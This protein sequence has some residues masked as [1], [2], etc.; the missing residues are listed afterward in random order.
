MQQGGM[1]ALRRLLQVGRQP[2]CQQMLIQRRNIFQS[3]PPLAVLV[4]CMDGR[5]LPSRLFKAE[6]GELFIV[7]NP[8]NFVPHSCTCSPTPEGGRACPS[9]EMAGLQLAVQKMAVPEII[10][11]GHADCKAA[12]A[13]KHLHVAKPTGSPGSGSQ[14]SLDLVNNWLHTHGS[15]SLDKYHRHMERPDEAIEFEGGGKKGAPISA[16]I[17]NDGKVSNTDR[18]AQINVLQQLEHLQSYDF[19][20]TRL[21]TGQIR[22]HA[23]YYNLLNGDM[24]VFNRAERRFVLLPT[25]DINSLSHYISVLKDS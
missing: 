16:V 7:R 10:V 11:C 18:L 9:G 8:G 6:I 1:L 15:T 3:K 5:L 19:I 2:I 4:T 21:E 12:E 25:A 17:E 13:L 20:R 22:L 14:H 23:T 24:F